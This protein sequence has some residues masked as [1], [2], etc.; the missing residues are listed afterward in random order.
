MSLNDWKASLSQLSPEQRQEL[1]EFLQ[2]LNIASGHSSPAS[3]AAS[4]PSMPGNRGH[5]APRWQ[6]PVIIICIVLLLAGGIGW[7]VGTWKKQQALK[8]NTL[9]REQQLQLE[10]AEARRPRSP[11]NMKFLRSQIGREVTVRGIPQAYE[12][13]MLFFHKNKDQGLRVEIFEP[14]IVLYQSTQLEEWV[15]NGTEL[16]IFGTLVTDPQS[17]GPMIDVKQQNQIK[18]VQPDGQ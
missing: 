10:E 6:M 4:H 7:A 2:A 16:E 18:V 15:K 8:E 14:H 17:G 1:I 12:V 13:G 3:P 5:A 9:N 11:T